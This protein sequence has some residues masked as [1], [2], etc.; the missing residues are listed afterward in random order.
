MLKFSNLLTVLFLRK[1]LSSKTILQVVLILVLGP[2]LF[3]LVLDIL[4]ISDDCIVQ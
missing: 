2:S 3:V 4:K 1:S